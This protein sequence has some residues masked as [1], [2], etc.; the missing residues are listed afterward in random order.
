[1]VTLFTI[2]KGFR[3]H[4]GDIQRNAIKSWTLLRPKCEI[5][6]LADDY[7]TAVV[8]E[9]LGVMHIANVQRNEFGTP[10]LDSAYKLAGEAATN[11]VHCYVNADIILTSSFMGA[12]QQVTTRDNQFM[13]TARRWNIDVTGLREFSDDWEA[14]LLKEVANKGDLGKHTQIDFWAYS[15]GLLNGI[16]PLAVGRMAFECWCLY[17]ARA[18]G[19]DLI[20]STEVVIS[21]HQNHDYSHHPQGAEG[22]GISVEAQRNRELVGGKPYFFTIR[23]RTH[24]LTKKGLKCARDVWW[25]WRWLRSAQVL[26]GDGNSFVTPLLEAFNKT[27][28][29]G[30]DI[31]LRVLRRWPR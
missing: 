6:L 1:M 23:D 19:A 10:L 15:K 13:L 11:L 9:E 12:L 14:D 24:F 5:I 31:A 30:R 17:K 18:A 3:G 4:I 26:S 29:L 16:P 28:N 8:A 27:I 21:V 20:D 22:I 7:G 2:P 25:L